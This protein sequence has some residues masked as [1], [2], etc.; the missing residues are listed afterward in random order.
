ME[1]PKHARSFR[2]YPIGA[3]VLILAVGA[4]LIIGGAR[5]VDARLRADLIRQ[6]SLVCWALDEA[7]VEGLSGGADDLSHPLYQSTKAKLSTTRALY[8]E[9]RFIYLTR[10]QPDGRIIFL[11]D[12]EDPSSG[13]YSP[14]GQ[15]YEEASEEFRALFRG[16]QPITEGPIRDRWGVWVS[17]LVPITSPSG[18]GVIAVLGM[19]V[20]ARTWRK[21]IYAESRAPIAFTAAMLALWA[22]SLVLLRRERPDRAL[23]P[24]LFRSEAFIAMGIGLVLTMFSVYVVYDT[25]RQRHR[26]AFM[27]KAELQAS[28]MQEFLD[29]V[30][31]S[32]LQSIAHFF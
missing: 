2:W 11:A 16:S 3:L 12:S 9:I 4:T 21:R 22:G 10:I 32:Y 29:R 14:P 23:R 15:V 25:E 13:D 27:R 1:R 6:A 8:P 5:E 18:R 19:D 31:K 7:E 17:A 28:L 30:G 26:D 24:A 20:D